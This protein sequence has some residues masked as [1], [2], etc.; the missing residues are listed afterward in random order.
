[1]SFDNPL[2]NWLG[3]FAIA[4]VAFYVMDHLVMFMQGL[5]LNFDLTPVQ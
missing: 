3:A 4:L 5:P 2:L 1:M